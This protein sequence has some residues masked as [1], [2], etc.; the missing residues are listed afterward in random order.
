MFNKTVQKYLASFV[1]DMALY[2]E[3]ILLA[4]M[5][6][7]NTSYHS[8]IATTP[9]KQLFG[10][11]AWLPSFPNPD[12]HRVH[13][14]KSS[15]AEN[16]LLQ[17]KFKFLAKNFAEKSGKK[18]KENFYKSALPHSFKIDLIWYEDVALLGKNAKLMPKCRAQ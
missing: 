4:L 12:I 10:S 15:S 5:L 7:Y 1:D 8:T 13:Y 3:N 9:F 14:G 18:Y 17:Q 11:K 16:F 6:S 2:W